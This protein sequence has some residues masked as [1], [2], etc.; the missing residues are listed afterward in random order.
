M[1]TPTILS[2]Q[3][4][5]NAWRSAKRP[6]EEGHEISFARAIESAVTA[7]LAQGVE[8]EAV[9]RLDVSKYRGHLENYSFDLTAD[10]LDGSYPLV[11]LSTAQDAVAAERLKTAEAEAKFDALQATLQPFK[12]LAVTTAYEQ[13]FGQA[14][15]DELSNPYRPGTDE[16]EAWDLGRSCGKAKHAPSPAPAAE[17]AMWQYR[18]YYDTCAGDGKP[19][20]GAWEEVVPRN[21]YT[22]TVADRVR[23]IQAYIEQGK[24]YELRALY[25]TPSPQPATTVPADRARLV[26]ECKLRVRAV[27]DESWHS[28]HGAQVVNVGQ[29]LDEAFAAIDRLASSAAQVPEDARDA[30]RYRWLRD[31]SATAAQSTPTVLARFPLCDED[32]PMLGGLDLDEAID[33]LLGF[34]AP[35]AGGEQS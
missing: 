16:R 27:R 30:A 17:P 19:G 28:A 9:G 32:H 15:R 10:D 26:E 33:L 24:R 7:K 25:A 5:A 34:A 6:Y 20:W 11:P 4:I 3:E 18:A 12:V 29:R 35:A 14:L 22:E 13:G 21:V 8:L 1:N 23:E 2:E 31:K